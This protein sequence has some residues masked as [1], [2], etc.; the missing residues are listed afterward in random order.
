MEADVD[1]GSDTA[2]GVSGS[3]S[4]DGPDESDDLGGTVL[5]VIAIAIMALLI[6]SKHLRKPSQRCS[7]PGPRGWCW[8]SRRE[9][10]LDR[11][12]SWSGISQ[13]WLRLC[14]PEGTSR[15]WVS[16]EAYDRR[17]DVPVAVVSSLRRTTE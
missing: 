8:R 1:R 11:V 10:W 14:E 2:G 17:S 7:L 16:C 6:V 4:P 5:G 3:T 15:W 12:H 13:I 9:Q